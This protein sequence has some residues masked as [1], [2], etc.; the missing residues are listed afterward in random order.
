MTLNELKT[1]ERGLLISNRSS[2]EEYGKA[3]AELRSLCEEYAGPKLS[4]DMLISDMAEKY[5][6][7]EKRLFEITGNEKHRKHIKIASELLKRET[8]SHAEVSKII[9]N[10]KVNFEEARNILRKTRIYKKV[11]PNTLREVLNATNQ[12]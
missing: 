5:I 7:K 9:A 4:E 2:L 12:K 1:R 10:R 6:S 3:Y 8:A 11:K